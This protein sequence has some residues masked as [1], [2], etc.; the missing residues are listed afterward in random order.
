MIFF[1]P[2]PQVTPYGLIIAPGL[3]GELIHAPRPRGRF[4]IQLNI[5]KEREIREAKRKMNSIF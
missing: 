2:S 3:E 5:L 1:F 4:P